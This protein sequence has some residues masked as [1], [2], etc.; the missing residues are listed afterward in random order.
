MTV[1]RQAC[2]RHLDCHSRA[3]GTFADR[4]RLRGGARR[5]GT[6]PR[7]CFAVAGSAFI[8]AQSCLFLLDP[9]PGGGKLRFGMKLALGIYLIFVFDGLR[10]RRGLPPAPQ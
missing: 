8:A 7:H 4:R 2:K 5:K 6:K 3:G 9:T 1:D 10:S